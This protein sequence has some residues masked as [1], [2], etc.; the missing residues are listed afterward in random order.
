MRLGDGIFSGG[1]RG[2]GGLWAVDE[3]VAG[4]QDWTVAK[5]PS[6]MLSDGVVSLNGDGRIVWRGGNWTLVLGCGRIG[7]GF[8]RAIEGRARLWFLGGCGGFGCKRMC[9]RVGDS[10][11][12]E[13]KSAPWGARLCSGP[14]GA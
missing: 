9:G 14:L 4:G 12:S 7:L 2:A 3:S 11:A 8:N 1:G 13:T 6:E 5:R 10:F